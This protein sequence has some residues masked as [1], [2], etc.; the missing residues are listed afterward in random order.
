MKKLEQQSSVDG[1]L[2]EKVMSESLRTVF[3]LCGACRTY[4]REKWFFS[5]CYP[6]FLT[7]FVVVNAE[8]FMPSGFDSAQNKFKKHT[9]LKPLSAWI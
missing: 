1:Q 3:R 7:S 2:L 4:S 8:S 5:T 6:A 9:L